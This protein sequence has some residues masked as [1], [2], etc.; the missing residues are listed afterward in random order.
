MAK[1]LID[2]DALM[3]LYEL[4][5]EL[6]EQAERLHVPIP[7]IRQNI[8]D[9]P[10]IEAIPVAVMERAILGIDFADQC[11]QTGRS[12]YELRRALKTVLS[13]Y[14]A[15]VYKRVEEQTRL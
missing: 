9:A 3:E 6:E 4:G 15:P 10:T 14:H 12:D 11:D 7:V 13:W 8:K 2:A 1:R 5:E